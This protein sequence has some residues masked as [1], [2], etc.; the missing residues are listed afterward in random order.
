MSQQLYISDLDG[1]LFQPDAS[2]SSHSRES[3]NKLLLSPDFQFTIATA[4]GF[5]STKQKLTGLNLRLPVILNNGAY[6]SDLA[7]GKHIII[8]SIPDALIEEVYQLIRSHA[9]YPMISSNDGQRDNLYCHKELNDGIRWFHGEC[10]QIKDSRLRE[11]HTYEQGLSERITGL[12]VID[13]LEVVK[14][15]H[16]SLAEQFSDT[17]SFHYYENIYSKGWYW[18]EI[19]SQQANKS[20]AIQQFCELY[21]YDVTA[22]TTF[23]D[24]LNDISM[25]RLAKH[26]I[27]V[28]NAV[29]PLKKIATEVIGKNT[30][31]AVVSYIT[32]KFK[33]HT[34]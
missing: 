12:V 33:L 32:E 9:R 31:E 25:L 28:E 24:N 6:I 11:A 19:S 29:D 17:L 30:E 16:A 3:L 4:R 26:K 2:L 23:G 7:S 20:S 13:E 14:G 10:K 21:D 34:V 18:L 8:N 5:H 1:T 15:I 27:A 22:L